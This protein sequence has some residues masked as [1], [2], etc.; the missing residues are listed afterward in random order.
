MLSKQKLHELTEAQQRKHEDE[1]RKINEE[2][3]L[4][5][6]KEISADDKAATPFLKVN[7]RKC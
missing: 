1:R 3:A 4:R 7:K 6:Q 2:V 5:M